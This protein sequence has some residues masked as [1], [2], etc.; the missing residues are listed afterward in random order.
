MNTLAQWFNLVTPLTCSRIPS[1]SHESEGR[2]KSTAPDLDAIQ[3]MDD[4]EEFQSEETEGA[5]EVEDQDHEMSD[6]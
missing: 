6:D 1:S 2:F 5:V 4:D 3:P